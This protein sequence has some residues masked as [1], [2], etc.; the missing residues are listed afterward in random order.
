MT[1]TSLNQLPQTNIFRKGDVFV[2]FGELFGRGYASGLVGE[3][4]KAGMEIVGITVGR[5][6][7]N[8][9]LRPL[10]AEEL[11]A[12]DRPALYDAEVSNA[13][14]TRTLRVGFRRIEIVGYEPV[15]FR[16]IQ[17]GHAVIRKRTEA[18]LRGLSCLP[19]LCLHVR[20]PRAQS[21]AHSILAEPRLIE[22]DQERRASAS[23]GWARAGAHRASQRQDR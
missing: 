20:H 6:D 4:R 14:E 22:H 15:E 19:D 1:I 2:L 21:F 16:A 5:R 18:V 11:A 10:N 9:A 8:N 7:E 12:A 13:V 17:R 3:A 23:L